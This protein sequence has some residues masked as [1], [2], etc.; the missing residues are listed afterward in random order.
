MELTLH[1]NLL[2]DTPYSGPYNSDRQFSKI[3]Q[4][5]EWRG[6]MEKT[7]IRHRADFKAKVALEALKGLQTAEL[8]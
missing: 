1:K 7:R 6:L 4:R 8:V 2:L 5:S 3:G